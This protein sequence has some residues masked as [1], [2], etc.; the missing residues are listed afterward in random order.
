M[1]NQALVS[2][3]KTP[4]VRLRSQNEKLATKPLGLTPAL[5]PVLT[6]RRSLRQPILSCTFTLLKHETSSAMFA[7]LLQCLQFLVLVFLGIP[8]ENALP[9]MQRVWT[10]V[11]A[12]V[13]LGLGVVGLATCTCVRNVTSRNNSYDFHLP[14]ISRNGNDLAKL[15][16]F[17]C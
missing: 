7:S 12:T 3:I 10:A 17:I 2:S 8:T 14:N 6:S 11:G 16:N 4:R 13:G 9:L 1:F 5:L 15:A